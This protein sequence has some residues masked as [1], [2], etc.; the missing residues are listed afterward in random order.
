M[1]QSTAQILPFPGGREPWV[2]KHT[3]A[4]YLGRSERWVEQQVRLGM[5]SR[6]IGGRRGFQLSAV[7]LWID[8]DRRPS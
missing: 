4:Q 1:Q 6:M 5:P 3:V 2:S 7:D 8:D